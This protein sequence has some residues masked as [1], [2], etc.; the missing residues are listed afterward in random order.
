VRRGSIDRTCP[1]TGSRGRPRA[2][3]RGHGRSRG[4]RWRSCLGPGTC[5]AD[6]GRLR[7]VRTGVRRVARVRSLAWGRSREVA[8]GW[9]DDHEGR[10]SSERD[11]VC[12]RSQTCGM[13]AAGSADMVVRR[14]R[15]RPRDERRSGPAIAFTGCASFRVGGSTTC[16]VRPGSGPMQDR[17]APPGRAPTG[18]SG[19]TDHAAHRPTA[20]LGPDRASCDNPYPREGP[21]DR[22]RRAQRDPPEEP[23]PT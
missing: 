23:Q 16:G 19:S 11:G 9:V 2:C 22:E 7:Q 3:C 8:S 20:T 1:D 18:P 17:R 12:G 5:R 6:P 15:A 10:A 4:R 13:C 21:L 14:V